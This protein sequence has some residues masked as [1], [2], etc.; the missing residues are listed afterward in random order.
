MKM[1]CEGQ[2][3]TDKVFLY[4]YNLKQ[5]QLDKM[6]EYG[7][8][9]GW[10]KY[11]DYR[12][13][14]TQIKRWDVQCSEKVSDERPP[15]DI[16]KLPGKRKLVFTEEVLSGGTIPKGYKIYIRYNDYEYP[17]DDF[18]NQIGITTEHLK[19]SLVGISECKLNGQDIAV[20]IK[21]K[22]YI[23][24]TIKHIKTGEMYKNLPISETVKFLGCK[25]SLISSLNKR[26]FKTK[27][28]DYSVTRHEG[29]K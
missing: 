14:L 17:V 12:F 23:F 28:D 22:N 3:V 25:R 5:W 21:P 6:K 9:R 27:F 20:V 7:S 2:I 11:K 19:R 16:K 18:C 13:R 24:Y 15:I 4:N 26:Y 8:K 29:M 1:E 10:F